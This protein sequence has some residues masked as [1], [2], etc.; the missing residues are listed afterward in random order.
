MKKLGS[1]IYSILGGASIGI[2][3]IVFLSLESKVLGALFFSIGLFIVL[4]NGLNLFTGKVCYIFEN[5]PSYT[6]FVMSVWLGNLI[7][8]TIVGYLVRLTRLT[9]LVD[10]AVGVVNVKLSDD[11]LS[12]FILA[13]F[14]NIM[15][16]IG[17]D[18]FKNNKHEVGKYLGILLSIFVFVYCGFEHCIANMFYFSV[19]NAWSLKALLY[20]LVM[21]LGNVVGAVIFPVSRQLYKK[22]TLRENAN[23]PVLSGR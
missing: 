23:P 19:A 21:T 6:L 11:L 14:C 9:A 4:V 8:T 3:G 20:L 1:F 2:G 15:M 10:K 5:P 7:G 16:F 17:V 18:G 22:Y 13:I 12:I